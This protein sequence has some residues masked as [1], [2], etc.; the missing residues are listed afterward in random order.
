M[1]I[2]VSQTKPETNT[3]VLDAQSLPMIA[4]TRHL[5]ELEQLKNWH[6]ANTAL[7]GSYPDELQNWY[8][9]LYALAEQATQEL[10]YSYQYTHLIRDVFFE[11]THKRDA[12]I[13]NAYKKICPNPQENL[14]AL[15]ILKPNHALFKPPFDKIDTGSL[16]KPLHALYGHYL[17][18][19]AYYP[20][21]AEL[22]LQATQT[23]HCVYQSKT[24]H[25]STEREIPRIIDDP[26]YAPLKRHRGLGKIWELIE[27]FFHALM[28]KIKG[29]TACEYT[30]RPCFFNTR[31]FSLM[32]QADAFINNMPLPS[33]V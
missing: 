28:N 26:R 29:L 12:H 24:N 27:D 8:K 10:S 7:L 1:Y 11:L 2:P 4:N 18:L 23:L 25:P 33:T 14:A 5:E 31:S 6:H 20:M 3:R 22:L 21:E 15:L 19:K 9:Q 17:K 30:N 16:P 32:E 13:L